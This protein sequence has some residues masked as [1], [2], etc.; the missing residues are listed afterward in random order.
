MSEADYIVVGGGSAGCVLA[1]R[2]AQDP[3]TRVLLLEAGP[4]ERGR[5]KMRIPL[6][7]RDT[8][9]DPAV[10][11]GFQTEP[12]AHA[13]GRVVPAPR[14]KVLGG[15]ASVN[16]MMYSRGCRADYDGW[17]SAGISGWG[18][19]DVL[20][21]FRRS[22][23]NWRGSSHWHG[24]DGPLT[25]ARH[26]RDDYIY[27]RLIAAAEKLGLRHL[28]DFHGADFE[29]FSAPDFNVHRGERASTVTRFLRPAMRRP[30]LQVITGALVRRVR[31]DGRRAR[32]VEYELDGAVR[33]AHAA[34]ATVL[35]AG[36]FNNP[37]LLML[38]G[39]GPA[40]ELQRHGI[41]VLQDL[42][43][44]GRNLQEHQSLAMIYEAS[45]PFTFDREL[46]LDRLA[47][48]ALRWQ[49]LGTGALAGL[50][51]SAQ[52]FVRTDPALT[53]PDLQMLVSPVSMLAQPWF[54]LW[55]RGAGH[56]LSVACVLVRPQSRGEVTLKSADPRAAPAIRLNLLQAE[57][58][59][60]AFRRIVRFVRRYFA[61]EPAASLVRG[62]RSPGPAVQSDAEIDAHLRKV[63]STAMH[64]TSTCAM[65]VDA[66]AVCD[67][68]LRVR[69]VEGLYAADASVLPT[70]VSGNTNAPAIM[71]AEKAADL[72]R[73]L[74]P[75]RPA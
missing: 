6:A 26:P 25:V 4:S 53:S 54:P 38:S 43:G 20:A 69:G 72:L 11:W 55:R 33:S 49:L 58:D 22:E 71:V 66:Q 62:E 41:A 27:P 37:Q 74:P 44:V 50:P 70:I 16:G 60:I 39:V 15:C 40:A 73:A 2:L 59:R 47:L 34:R 28:D 24:A 57:A 1:A 29:G 17:A 35:C 63:V 32:G 64:P 42:P 18:Y 9:R 45:G 13:D 56:V 30:N 46:R 67:P 5:L 7:W 8:F 21:Y 19:D 23:T 31:F 51:V 12:E 10:S 68:G 75:A 65:G 14:G 61:T 48:A 36:A 52:G 3:G